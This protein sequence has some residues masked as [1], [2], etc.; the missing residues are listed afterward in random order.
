MNKELTPLKAFEEIKKYL[1]KLQF[2]FLEEELGIIETALKDYERLLKL[3]KTAEW[4]DEKLQTKK[5]LKAL[6]IIKEKNIDAQMIKQSGCL[7]HY[8]TLY[9]LVYH[10]VASADIYW[11]FPTQTEYDLLKEV[12]L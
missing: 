9:R 2:H 3:R 4:A 11:R 7:E 1:V 5:K 10:D 12:L 6:E 8:C